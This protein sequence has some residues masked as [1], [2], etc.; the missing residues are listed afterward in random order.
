MRFLI[1]S[2]SGINLASEVAIT[3]YRELKQDT[4]LTNLRISLS[5]L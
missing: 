1:Y 5:Y 2:H 3:I 4:E